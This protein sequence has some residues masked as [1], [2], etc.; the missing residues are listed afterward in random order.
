MPDSEILLCLLESI[1]ILRK[2]DLLC[3]NFE[4]N[5]PDVCMST[6]QDS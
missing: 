4:L 2:E 6:V 1:V 5:C 3:E